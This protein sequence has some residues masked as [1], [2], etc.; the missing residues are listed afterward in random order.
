MEIKGLERDSVKVEAGT[1][2]DDIVGMEDVSLKVRGFSSPTA[3]AIRAK[4]ERR[5]SKT[6]RMSDGSLKPEVALT[7]LGETLFEVVLIDWKGFTNNGKDVP[8][9]AELAEEWL[10]NPN[11]AAFADAVTI[12]AQLVDRGLGEAS[13]ELAGNLKRPSRGRPS[14]EPVP[15]G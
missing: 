2:V 7:I 1:W 4:K 8:Y 10:T 3:I 12:A 11:F 5:V 13:G 14:T 15:A 6:G 9:S